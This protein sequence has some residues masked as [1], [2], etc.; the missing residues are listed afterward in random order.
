[1][2]TRD[3]ALTKLTRLHDES[4]PTPHRLASLQRNYSLQVGRIMKLA[5]EKG[6]WW[7]RSKIPHLEPQTDSWSG[8]PMKNRRWR[9]LRL[10]KR[11]NYFSLIFLSKNMNLLYQGWGLWGHQ[12]G[13]THLGKPGWGAPWWVVSTQVPPSGGS[14]LQKLSFI[15]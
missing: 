7:R 15:V 9:Q 1:M 8:L 13:T 3:Q 12:V 10:V 6:W 14:R 2:D 4:H 11:D 5:M